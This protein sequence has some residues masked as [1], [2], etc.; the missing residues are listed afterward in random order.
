MKRYYFH[1]EYGHGEMLEDKDGEFMRYTDH[2]D[3]MVEL[4]KKK[5]AVEDGASK[6]QTD[7]DQLEDEL[8]DAKEALRDVLDWI[9]CSQSLSA[10]E[11]IC[12]RGLKE[13]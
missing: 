2:Q 11:A 1:T 4:I 13:C 7:M 3:A 9:T 10:L 8:A 5:W 6:L 12:K